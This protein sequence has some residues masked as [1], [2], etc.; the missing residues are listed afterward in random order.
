MTWKSQPRSKSGKDTGSVYALPRTPDGLLKI[1]YRGIKF[2]NFQTAPATAHFTQNGKWS[3]PLSPSQERGLPE[4]AVEAIRDFVAIFLP[5]FK[6]K[7]F[8]SSKLC[9]YT[10]T[11][12]NSFLVS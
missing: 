4:P 12:D 10:D 2:T 11:L 1:G 3:I 8:H 7:P 6:D 9:W 5:E